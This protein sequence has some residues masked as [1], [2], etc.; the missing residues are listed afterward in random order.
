MDPVLMYIAAAHYAL[1]I[2]AG[3]W[4]FHVRK[5]HG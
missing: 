2:V 3:I 5:R 1:A 4:A